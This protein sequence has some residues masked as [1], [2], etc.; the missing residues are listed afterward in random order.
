MKRTALLVLLAGC[1]HEP[2]PPAPSAFPEFHATALPEPRALALASPGPFPSFERE[3]PDLD[4]PSLPPPRPFSPEPGWRFGDDRALQ[5]LPPS[6]GYA[7]NHASALESLDHLA[8]LQD[9]DGSWSPAPA[10]A[11]CGPGSD[12]DRVATTALALLAFLRAGMSTLESTIHGGV[13]LDE[14][15]RRGLR[16]LVADQDVPGGV[17]RRSLI[18]RAL[19]AAV[20]AEASDRT[21]TLLLQ[22]DA[23]RAT[24][25]LLASSLE[26][27]DADS[28]A[29]AAEALFRNYPFD[30][31]HA[32]WVSKA[33]SALDALPPPADGTAL[34]R[35][36]VARMLLDQNKGDARLH[37]AALGLLRSKPGPDHPDLPYWQAGTRALFKYDGPN[38]VMWRTWRDSL[39]PILEDRRRYATCPQ[40]AALFSLA[41][42]EI[43]RPVW[44]SRYGYRSA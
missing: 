17:P 5:P 8:R 36:V 10:C 1:G 31:A 41:L 2:P 12:M 4:L 3:V 34:A 23:A 37:E 44:R 18:Q 20:F 29:A 32:D 28:V 15:L 24:T 26:G 9:E 42:L 30:R 6:C 43:H 11:E 22:E 13:R 19:T 7:R 16:W 25:L 40:A 39:L 27:A 38:G 35:T 21:S 14:A 33:R